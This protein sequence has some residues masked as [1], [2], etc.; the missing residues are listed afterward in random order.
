ME[1]VASRS[2][3][4]IFKED[5][6]QYF[7][8]DVLFESVTTFIGRFHEPFN[9][10]AISD[11]IAD[12]DKFVKAKLLKEWAESGPAGTKIHEQL[13]TYI[14]TNKVPKKASQQ[15][16][17]GVNFLKDM[18]KKGWVPL[19]IELVM[20][21]ELMQLAG[22]A[23]LILINV[24]TGKMIIADWKTCKNIPKKS[25]YSSNYIGDDDFGV[26][27]FNYGP[28]TFFEPIS[29]IEDC[30]FN[31]YALQLSIYQVMGELNYGFDIV[32]RLLVHLKKGCTRYDILETPYLFAEVQSMLLYNELTN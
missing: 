19:H 24:K 23:D 16:I 31:K 18:A 21:C 10:E 6:H 4:I 13:E 25:Y 8:N 15:F 27:K 20:Y 9:A 5:Q 29:H 17:A 12:G 30:K 26:P 22:T 7:V 14:K 32:G 2:K 3:N 1:L 28:K 11:K